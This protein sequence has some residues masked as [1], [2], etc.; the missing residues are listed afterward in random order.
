MRISNLGFINTVK[1]NL[2]TPA[3]EMGR[4]YAQTSS[5]KRLQ[6]LSDDPQAMVRA[7][8]A[9]AS[10]GELEARRSVAQQG[11]ELLSAT[12][13]ALGRVTDS[14]SQAKDLALRAATSS[15]GDSERA[16]LAD[17]VRSLRSAL[18]LTGNAN[19]GGHY[20]FSGSRTDTPPLQEGATAALPVAYEGN[21]TALTYQASADQRTAVGFT[22]AEVFNYPDGS[23]TRAVPDV[24]QDVFST[25]SSLADAIETG[26]NTQLGQLTTDLDQ[27]H[28]HTVN[29][30]AQGGV[31]A[32]QWSATLSAADDTSI[33]LNQVLADEE[34]VDYTSAIVELSNL[35]TAY[36]AA[37]GL[38]SQMLSLPN[39]FDQQ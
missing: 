34:S 2:A 37:L 13:T 32:Q 27:L 24:D 1:R 8:G 17:Q 18:V 16:A 9:H 15:L 6:K 33:L 35:Q 36:Q 38:T 14:L 23:G 30:R 26:D 21:Y 28:A 12:D 7:L 10:L 39:L 19:V 22:G 25:L 31:L 4:L 20:L 11:Q 3:E 29:L 5:G